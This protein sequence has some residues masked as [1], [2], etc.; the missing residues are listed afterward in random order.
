MTLF[1]RH[2]LRLGSLQQ[3]SVLQPHDGGLAAAAI[4]ASSE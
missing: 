2:W 3:S 1:R 4:L